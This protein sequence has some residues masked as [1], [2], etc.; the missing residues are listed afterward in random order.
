MIPRTPATGFPTTR[1]PMPLRNVRA[2]PMTVRMYPILGF[3]FGVGAGFSACGAP[4]AAGL[5]LIGAPQLEQN[6]LPSSTDEPQFGQYNSCSEKLGRP[7]HLSF[8]PNWRAKAGPSR[9]FRLHSFAGGVAR[10]ERGDKNS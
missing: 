4:V 2:P 9:N 7:F 5:P 8:I 3:A 6:V 1:Y 10:T